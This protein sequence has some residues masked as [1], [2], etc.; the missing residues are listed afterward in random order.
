MSGK[1][2]LFDRTLLAS[3]LQP[4]SLNQPECK[5]RVNLKIVEQRNESTGDKELKFEI[6]RSDDFEFL[7]ADVI[8]ND[9]YQA[10]AREHDLTVDFDTFPMIIINHLLPK[11]IVDA[12]EN[13]A[14]RPHGRETPQETDTKPT[15]ITIKLDSEKNY[16]TFE[17]CSKTPL[18]KGRIFSIK[19]AAVRGDQFIAHLLQIC[20]NQTTEL[21]ALKKKAEELEHM[22]PLYAKIKNDYEKVEG[23]QQNC[24]A[25]SERN[26]DLEDELELAKEERETIRV[27]AEEKDC[28]IEELETCCENYLKIIEESKEEIEVVGIMLKEEQASVDKLH[29]NVTLQQ[30]EIRRLGSEIA[31]LT[32][33]LENSEG[34]LKKR[35]IEQSLISVDMRK[36]RELESELRDKELVI[37]SLTEKSSLS[38]IE[39]DDERIKLHELSESHDRLQKE[40]EGL[41]QKLNLY[42][43]ERSGFSPSVGFTASNTTSRNGYR[44]VL[45]GGLLNT[46]DEKNSST[47][48]IYRSKNPTTPYA[49][50]CTNETTDVSNDSP[51]RNS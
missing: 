16:C 2:C 41:K 38:R 8:N 24:Q 37:K 40:N 1:S 21:T 46:P 19:L 10:L 47:P 32:R 44:N 7:Y 25:L 14:A 31:S 30:K 33:K 42:R 13:I 28:K 39:L 35:D 27:I 34:L 49:L 26:R 23:I 43:M 4:L 9:R 12:T 18:S 17:I 11:A 50:R 51:F 3:L 22:K 6:S 48:G 5:R 36:L 29:K 20:S 15:E 45:G